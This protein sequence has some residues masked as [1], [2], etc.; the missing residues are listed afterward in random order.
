MHGQGEVVLREIGVITDAHSLLELREARHH[1]L[2]LGFGDAEQP[3][4]ALGQATHVPGQLQQPGEHIGVEHAPHLRRHPGQKKELDASVFQGKAAGHAAGVQHHC[5][6]RNQGQA[7]VTLQPGNL[8]FL[9]IAVE[10]GQQRLVVPE[11][12]SQGL[13]RRGRGQVVIGGPQAPGDDDEPGAAQRPE[14]KLPKPRRLIPDNSDPLHRDPGFVKPPG[15]VARIK[16]GHPPADQ[17]GAGGDD[18]TLH[19]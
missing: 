16:I 3:Q 6:L 19:D 5:A 9:Q 7:A 14:Q 13:G 15:R 2:Q 8:T 4:G 12:Q 1:F 17:L 10:A 11:R 18:F